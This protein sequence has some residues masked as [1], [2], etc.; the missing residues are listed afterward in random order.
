[1][2]KTNKKTLKKSPRRLPALPIY[3]GLFLL[4]WIFCAF[5]YDDVFYIAQQH[6]YFAFDA[7]LLREVTDFWY[8]SAIVLGRFLMLSFHYPLIG[9]VFYAAVLT[10][11]AYLVNY[12]AKLKG[13]LTL[14]GLLVP[15]GWLVFLESLRLNLFY[16]YEPSFFMY[17]PVIFL[18]ILLIASVVVRCVMKRPFPSFLKAEKGDG[19]VPQYAFVGVAVLITVGMTYAAVEPLQNTIVTARLQRQLQ[20]YRWEDMVETAKKAE[21][22]TRPIC[23]YNAL[24]LAYSNQLE[25]RLFDTYYQYPKSHLTNRNEYE[26]IGTFYYTADIALYAG[27][28]NPSWHNN[29]DHLTMEGLSAYKLK[30]IFLSALVNNELAAAEKILYIIEQMPF[31]GS[32][33]DKYSPM[34]YDRNLVLHDEVL[35]KVCKL[36]PKKDAVEQDFFVP[37]LL[38]YYVDGGECLPEGTGTYTLAA[39]LYTKNIGNFI[40]S[41][42]KMPPMSM[43]PPTY[44]EGIII[45]DM[46]LKK[47]QANYSPSVLNGMRQ[48]R[49]EAKM[50]PTS[51]AKE[52]A[53]TLKDKYLGMYSFYY[54]YQN[55]PDENYPVPSSDK[56]EGNKV[57]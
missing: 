6:T 5:I 49:S 23:A 18:L 33:V 52:K 14:I 36:L 13:Y 20:D 3:L 24:A 44:E 22:P 46:H 47:K 38:G 19:N 34:L 7:Q 12:I 53:Q 8:G 29:I 17:I 31:E 41:L 48:M 26:D 51:D 56:E 55:V 45:N 50:L 9:G 39:S 32:F 30:T 54:F 4:L 16:R 1:M 27:L 28:A 43:L 40:Y 57:N 42:S 11:I 35:A 10:T 21:R 37:L 25:Q 15:M 2:A